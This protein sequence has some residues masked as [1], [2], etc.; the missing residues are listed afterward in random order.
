MGRGSQ[1]WPR[2]RS[3]LSSLFLGLGLPHAGHHVSV[4]PPP[5]FPAAGARAP[6]CREGRNSAGW[7]EEGHAMK[8]WMRIS[9]ALQGRQ[10]GRSVH[11][12]A[13]AASSSLPLFLSC[14]LLCSCVAQWFQVPFPAHCLE[15]ITSVTAPSSPPLL[16]LL[17]C[18][19]LEGNTRGFPGGSD[20]KE[21]ACNEG[22]LGFTPEWG[23]SPGEG[24]GNP[25]QYS[26]LENS[27]D[28]GAWRATVY[29][30]TKSQI[31]LSD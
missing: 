1:R 13:S 31:R 17:L 2:F 30:V 9:K 14:R 7:R 18:A 21:S 6:V 20:C 11:S 8:K 24:N 15:A 25:L 5:V 3:G 29:G 22:D 23:R 12:R 28:R 4:K 26:C 19:S 16:F 10:R 27:M